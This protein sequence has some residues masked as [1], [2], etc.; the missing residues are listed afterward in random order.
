MNPSYVYMTICSTLLRNI[1]VGIPK[2][3]FRGLLQN[4][5]WPVRA[6]IF[7]NLHFGCHIWNQ[8][9]K[10]HQYANATR[11]I[12]KKSEKGPP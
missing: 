9:I 10:M 6:K 2:V 11:I 12:S 1:T 7:Q 5:N 8:H 3:D 4:F